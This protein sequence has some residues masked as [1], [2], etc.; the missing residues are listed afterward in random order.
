MRLRLWLALQVRSVVV[1]GG[2]LAGLQA[3]VGLRALGYDGLLTLLCAEDEPPYDRPPLSKEVLAGI[4]S[5]TTLEADWAALDVDVRLSTPAVGLSP[6]AV[7]LAGA[8]VPADGVVLACGSEPVRVPGATVLHTSRD[9]L[10]LRDRLRPGA[11][12]AVLGAGWVGAEVATAAARAG[13]QVEVHEALGSPL[14]GS[15]PA[16]VG[17]RTLPWYAVLGIGV[18]L[19]VRVEDVTRLGADVVVAGIGVR[20]ATGWLGGSAVELDPRDGAV[21]VDASLRTSLPGVVAVGDCV[22]WTS[23]RWG[24]RIRVAHWDAALR[25]PAVAAASLLGSAA[26][27]D[28]VPYSWSDQLGHTLQML[29]VPSTGSRVV[30]RET[31]TGWSA[32]WLHGRRL[33]AVVAADS[34][35]DVTQGR[36]LIESGAD[37]EPGRLASGPVRDAAR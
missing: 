19:G 26:V 14:A 22:A 6:G 29:G 27:F 31:P 7:L 10:V 4:S 3:L 35:R 20:P 28:P 34:P 33:V 17:S 11:R 12:V 36:R 15:L 16:A 24:R 25:G 37:V 13:C 8:E 9:A 32:C 18:H 5:S 2:G 30:W 23:A 1:V 21:L